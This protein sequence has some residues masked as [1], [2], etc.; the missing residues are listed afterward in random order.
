[1]R[2]RK[3][4][5]KLG[6]SSS[7]RKELMASLVC[8]LIEEKRIATTL[9]KAKLASRLADRMITLGLKGTLAARRQALSALTRDDRV[10][11]LFTELAPQFKDRK[12]GYTRVVRLGRRVGDSAETALLEWVGVA[13][14]DKRRKKKEEKKPGE[15]EGTK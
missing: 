2:H 4:A 8:H 15:P 5:T 12:G 10:A 9:V 1:M 11:K 6:R 3:E 13:I 7:H 14:P